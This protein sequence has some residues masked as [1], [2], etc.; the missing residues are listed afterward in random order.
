MKWNI[1]STSYAAAMPADH[2]PVPAGGAAKCPIDHAS[3]PPEAIAAHQAR[4]A[5]EKA[6]A[7]QAAQCPIDHASLPPEAIAAHKARA[8]KKAECP[9]D[10][11]AMKGTM[12]ALGAAVGAPNAL[13]PVNH[14]PEGL[15]ATDRA[16]GQVTDLSTERTMST[17]PRPATKEDS[18]GGGDEKVWAYP[19]PQQFYVSSETGRAW[20][21]PELRERGGL[22]P[23]RPRPQG[24]G[25]TR[26]RYRHDCRHPQLYQR[27]RMGRDHEVGE[28]AAG[29]SRAQ[30]IPVGTS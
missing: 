17:I 29:V 22:T 4:A 6:K 9:I 2:P 25:D 28:A 7:A 18:Y 20:V 26:R 30:R 16:P 5:A 3:L 12:G 24:M 15:S 19:S 1:G 14:I 21:E 27:G 8:E 23:E 13:N 10:H 11:G